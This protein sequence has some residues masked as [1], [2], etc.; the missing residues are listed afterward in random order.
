MSSPRPYRAGES[1]E[2]YCRACKTDRMHR[3]MAADA[4][5]R[6]IRVVCGYCGSEHNFRGG[7]RVA[8]TGAASQAQPPERAPSAARAPAAP[9]PIVSDRERSA[10]GMAD[11][12][13]AGPAAADL[14]MLLRR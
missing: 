6:P 1:I 9:F 10:S 5:G 7:P 12:F 2:D 11:Q 14:E 8:T 4:Q 13:P 3:V